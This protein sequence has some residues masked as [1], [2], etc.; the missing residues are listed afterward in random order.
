MSTAEERLARLEVLVSE[1][2]DDLKE[3]RARN[4]FELSGLKAEVRELV[5]VAHMGRGALWLLLPTGT[6]LGWLINVL[7]TMWHPK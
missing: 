1:L 6:A 5:R 7:L 3:E 4:G 2:R